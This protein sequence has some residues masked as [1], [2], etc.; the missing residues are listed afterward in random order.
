MKALYSERP[1]ELL[2]AIQKLEKADDSLKSRL[3]NVWKRNVYFLNGMQSFSSDDLNYFEVTG[4]L[5]LGRSSQ[6]S[7]YNAYTTNEIEPLVV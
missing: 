3:S 2:Q 7:R 1:E 4:G 5:A 6:Q